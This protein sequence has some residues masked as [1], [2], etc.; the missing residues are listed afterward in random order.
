[1][2]ACMR[3][4]EAVAGC[5]WLHACPPSRLGGLGGILYDMAVHAWGTL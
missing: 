1:M 4:G 3:G 5:A 2:A